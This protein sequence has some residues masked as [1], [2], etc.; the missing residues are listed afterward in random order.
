MNG[1]NNIVD[2]QTTLI[3]S[4]VVIINQLDEV[5]ILVFLFSRIGFLV[6][7]LTFRLDLASIRKY[8]IIMSSQVWNRKFISVLSSENIFIFK[9]KD[10]IRIVITGAAGQIAYS[11]LY[12]ICNGDVFGK[13]QVRF[14]FF[15]PKKFRS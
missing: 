5:K 2:R 12:P 1:S 6:S 8:F 7:I 11:L 9:N 3:I 15:S 13:D 10:P 14:I 4:L